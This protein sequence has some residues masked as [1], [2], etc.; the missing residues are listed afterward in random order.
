MA[1]WIETLNDALQDTLREPNIGH[2][3]ESA[4]QSTLA[5]TMVSVAA[6]AHATPHN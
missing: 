1:L 6:A 4:R 2:S 5:R 3:D